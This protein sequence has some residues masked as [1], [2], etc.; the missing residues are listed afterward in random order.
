[1]PTK[2][3]ILLLFPIYFFG[4]TKVREE[5]SK[6][7][8]YKISL[9]GTLAVNENYTLTTDDDEMLFNLNGIFINNSVGY[10]FNDRMSTGLN[11][12]YD[13]YSRQV[14]NFL[15]VFV[16]VRYNFIADSENVFVRA[17]YGKLFQIADSFEKG[18]TYKIGLGY[19]LFDKN[20]RNSF[21]FGLDYSRKRFG[22]ASEYKLSSVSLFIEFMLF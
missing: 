9:A 20:Y 15:P 3:F 21:L 16:D 4:Q 11:V 14:L 7:L 18:S 12:E 2:F 6:G 8:F 13:Y 5:K 10:Q 19:Q 17:G 22:D 1:M